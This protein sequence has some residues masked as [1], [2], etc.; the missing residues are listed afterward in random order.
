VTIQ[1]PMHVT[2]RHVANCS[3]HSVCL[4]HNCKE[5]SLSNSIWH[6]VL[7]LL[8]KMSFGVHFPIILCQTNRQYLVWWTVSVTQEFSVGCIRSEERSECMRRWTRYAFPTRNVILFFVF[9]L[10]CN[11]FCFTDR[12]HVRNGLRGFPIILYEHY[13]SV[14]ACPS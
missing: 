7:N 1:Q 4:F 10:Q 11:L 13:L 3:R 8:A 2:S 12:T 14:A 9:W 5:C 6:L